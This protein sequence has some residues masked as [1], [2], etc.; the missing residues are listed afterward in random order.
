MHINS[1]G[2]YFI[3][4]LVIIFLATVKQIVRAYGIEPL[5][6]FELNKTL[7]NDYAGH[8]VKEILLLIVSMDFISNL[9][10][11]LWLVVATAQIDLALVDLFWGAIIH[12]KVLQKD[13]RMTTHYDVIK[14]QTRIGTNDL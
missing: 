9:R 10:L 11:I 4:N 2:R 12:W 6:K 5:H 13:L 3:L 8:D 1:W 7:P 14:A